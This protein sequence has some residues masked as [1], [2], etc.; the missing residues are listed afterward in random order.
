MRHEARLPPLVG[1]APGSLSAVAPANAES[2]NLAELVGTQVGAQ[3]PA[4]LPKG[5]VT[6]ALLEAFTWLGDARLTPVADQGSCACCWAVASVGC[7]NDRLA[8]RYG[9]NP[10]L[11]FQ[12]LMA[13]ASA[14]G[15]CATCSAH[16]GFLHLRDVG[17]TRGASERVAEEVPCAEAARV[18]AG[19]APRSSA[20]ILALQSAILHGGPVATTMRL[21]SDF[22]VGSDPR[23]GAPFQETEGVYVHADGQKNYGV[24]PARCRDLGAHCVVLV[25]WGTTGSS[26]RYWDARNSWGAAWGS[27]G[28]FRVAMTD[29]A[30]NNASVGVDL[31]LVTVQGNVTK[32]RFGNIWTEP[33]L[34]TPLY[35]TPVRSSPDLRSLAVVLLCA[36][37]LLLLLRWRRPAG[38]SS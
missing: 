3:L 31:A 9:R 37:L 26:L 16:A 11:D 7:V 6:G 23:L 12:Q 2:L 30:L 10:G 17:V 5:E 27:G 14:C 24:E 22:L 13:C 33:E 32:R 18:R 1:G 21:Y 19:G 36:A 20:S 25:G 29:A 35:S 15:W 8:L 28:Y 34:L 38:Q 4:G